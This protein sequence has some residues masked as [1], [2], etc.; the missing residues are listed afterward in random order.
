MSAYAKII[1]CMYIL[2]IYE[3]T[4]NSVGHF[5]TLSSFQWGAD[6]S[7]K[8]PLAVSLAGNI[9]GCHN[10]EATSGI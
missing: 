10:W 1:K 9:F 7:P 6:F 2:C 4:V 8:E 3:L 5:S